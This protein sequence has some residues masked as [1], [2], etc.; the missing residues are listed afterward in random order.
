[1]I[2]TAEVIGKAQIKGKAVVV[3]GAMRPER[4]SNSDAAFNLG[5]AVGI[6]MDKDEGAY[7]AMNGIARRYDQVKRC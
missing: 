6:V 1:M 4:F 5:V 2:E 3:T 7:V